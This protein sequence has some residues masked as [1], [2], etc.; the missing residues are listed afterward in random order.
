MSEEKAA[1]PAWL[2]YLPAV[3]VL[4]VVVGALA[5]ASGG[6]DDGGDDDVAAP[7]DGGSTPVDGPPALAAFEGEDP[8]GA[9]DCDRDTGRL[10]IPMVYAPNCV[11]LWEEGR[12]NGGAT[13]QGVTEDEIKVAIYIS[14]DNAEASAAV[15][16]MVGQDLP[17][18]EE[19]DTDRQR[20]FDALNALWETYGRTVS[21]ELLHATGTA[22]DDAAAKADAIRA[23]EEMD[24]FAVLG[25][26][27]GT[28]AFAEELAARE[29]VCFCAEAY[30]AER[31]EE[32]DPY[33][34]S[35]G[36]SST[37]MASYIADLVE[38]LAGQPAEHAGEALQSTERKFALVRGDTPDDA[39]EESAELVIEELSSRGIEVIDQEYSFEFATAQEQSGTFVARM[40]DAGVTSIIFSGDAF[41][42]YFLT[43]AATAQEWFPEWIMTGSGL[44]DTAAASRS[45]DQRQWEHAFGISALLARVDRAVTEDEVSFIDWYDDTEF[46]SLPAELAT[47][48]TFF[49]GVHLAGPNLTPETFRDGLFSFEP[50]GGDITNWGVSYGTETWGRTDFSGADDITLIWWDADAEGPHEVQEE[51]E[52]GR[53]LWRYVDGGRRYGPGELAGADHSPFFSE[54]GAT[55]FLSE[56]P[57]GDLP[58]AYEPR[59][60]RTG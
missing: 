51:G 15:E 2:R 25:G 11:P 10:M 48:P 20:V 5:F 1:R 53:G 36:M 37:F 19:T 4:A 27:L 57:A 44:V 14:P 16:D 38:S 30:P 56:R 8:L 35:S 41:M 6:G 13:Y 17:T 42:P 21:Y 3:V 26:P 54:E 22:T 43:T 32:W 29:V 18:D 59:Q 7:D 47:A 60:S 28:K 33:I 31:Y 46:E 55:L 24:V 34:W 52:T 58:P 9:P 39:Y 49:N 40:K 12:D 45:Y 23:A 50:T